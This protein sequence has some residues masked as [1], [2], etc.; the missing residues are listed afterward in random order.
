MT[1]SP[2]LK[3]AVSAIVLFCTGVLCCLCLQHGLYFSMAFSILTA[4]GILLLL[5]M[6]V[7]AGKDRILHILESISR[8]HLS[9]HYTALSATPSDRQIEH[10]LNRLIDRLHSKQAQTETDRQYY[11]SLLNTIDTFLIVF[12]ANGNIQWMNR[13]AIEGLTGFNAHHIK[14]LEALN[15]SFPEFL[16]SLVPGDTQTIGIRQDPDMELAATLTYYRKPGQQLRICSLRNVHR[17]LENKELEAWQKLVRVLTHE[18]MNSITP[19]ISLSDTLCERAQPLQDSQPA[20][21]QGLQ[22]IHRRSKGLLQFIENY[23]KLTRLPLPVRTPVHMDKLLDDLHKLFPVCR[24]KNNTPGLIL[25]IDR[26]QMEQVLINLLKNAC[27]A[28]AHRPHPEISLHTSC[29]G[30]TFRFQILDN[31]EGILPEVA[32]KIFIP[33]FTTKP[34]GSGIGLSLCKQIVAHHGGNISVKSEFKKGSLFQ[35]ELP[36]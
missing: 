23:R 26:T 4:L 36:V 13:P 27:D 10:L 32:D 3:T 19:I 34:S 24:I 25:N 28:T 17:L 5:C 30:R 16:Q 21:Y 8:N 31:G 35:I 1:L 14:E 22:T 18:I 15:A 9:D 12:D 33:F 6:Q 11:E 7:K 29:T 2:T 20:M